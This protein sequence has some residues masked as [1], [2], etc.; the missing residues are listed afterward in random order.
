MSD[1]RRG[2]PRA[3]GQGMNGERTPG[4]AGGGPGTPGFLARR[5]FARDR[6]DSITGAKGGEREDRSAWFRAVYESAAR[7]A[8]AVPWA[9]L[10]PKQA[11][12]DWLA[13]N[14]GEG[15]RALDVA[16]GLG[17]NA[18]E[19]AGAGYRTTAFDLAPEAVAWA[20]ERFP[21]SAVDYRAADLFN[22]PA[23]WDGHFDLVH[24]CYTLQALDGA[25]RAT[26]F[27]AL[28]RLVAPGGRL[29]VITRT[30]PEGADVDGPPWPLTPQELARFDALGF[31][32]EEATPYEIVKGERVIPHV[33]AVFSRR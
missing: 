6:L 10:A 11:L 7:D 9:D 31:T 8:A 26:A 18:E 20:R 30:R 21:E 29:L 19:L 25:L 13:D 15:R 32:R 2:V 12:S 4:L 28:A 5:D 3:N 22:L 23:E 16:C 17:D 1:R 33:R 14:P 27:P 24:E